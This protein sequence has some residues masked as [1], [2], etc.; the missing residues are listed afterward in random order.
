MQLRIVVRTVSGQRAAISVD[1]DDT[2]EKFQAALERIHG[3]PVPLQVLLLTKSRDGQMVPGRRLYEY[4]LTQDDEILL[5]RELPQRPK[6]KPPIISLDHS[7]S[8]RKLR[9]SFHSNRPIGR[10]SQGGR[11]SLGSRKS[12]PEKIGKAKARLQTALPLPPRPTCPPPVVNISDVSETLSQETRTASKPALHTA[13]TREPMSEAAP[14]INSQ[15][16]GCDIPKVIQDNGG[17]KTALH[18]QE[19]CQQDDPMVLIKGDDQGTA[20]VPSLQVKPP[21]SDSL[22]SAMTSGS[23]TIAPGP[24]PPCKESMSG[25]HMQQKNPGSSSGSRVPS[26]SSGQ[27]DAT[28]AATCPSSVPRKVNSVSG[29]TAAV[30]PMAHASLSWSP[31]TTLSGRGEASPPT[32]ARLVGPH[33]SGFPMS[34]G[35]S[36]GSRER[37]LAAAAGMACPPQPTARVRRSDL[38]QI[39]RLGVGAFGVVT[40]E[41]DRR[42]G[43]T[44]ALKA[45]S[46][47]YLAQLRMEY[48][49]LNEKRILKMVESP[50]VVRLIATYN[51][52]EHV[53][54][55]LEAAL[56]GE[57]FTTYERLRLYGSERHARFYVAC[58]TEALTHLHERHVI[59]RDLKPENLLLD[60]RGYCKLTD[61]G[62][63]KVTHGQTYT[64]VG[65][66]DYMA[67]E[68]ILCTGHTKAVDWWMLGV[69]LFELLAG[70]APF[71]ADTTQ[72]VYELVK[73]GID[74][75][76][77]PHEC[78]RLATDLVRALCNH[79]PE[80]R[81]RT[82]PLREHPFFRGFEWPALRALRLTPPHIPHVRGPRDLAN[83]R[84]CD[85]EDPPVTPYQDTGSGWDAGFEDDSLGSSA[86]RAGD[87]ADAAQH[88]RQQQHRQVAT[89]GGG[90][91]HSS[92]GSSHCQSTRWQSVTQC[93]KASVMA[94]RMQV[95]PPASP[96][97]GGG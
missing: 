36:P 87:A 20:P 78:R 41:A 82:P 14:G 9:K 61:M 5:V 2:V 63:A 42:T 43:R 75:V 8:G 88:Y 59:Y 50:F 86:P 95:S 69:L 23:G 46:K 11:K 91:H 71:E 33:N 44:Y 53:Y 48:S 89:S 30:M 74:A 4:D 7:C 73:R 58:V 67:P 72:Q 76:R 17:T 68:V 52:R 1:A 79:T 54:F 39:G 62:L 70:R 90:S 60:S 24:P 80:A 57:L 15:A 27:K 18:V 94:Q 51:G 81:L 37:V 85:G 97:L 35:S 47:G 84:A 45:V 12:D 64:L 56:G 21:R 28:A 96:V 93:S 40:L 83:F 19:L 66:P 65:T 22:H 49:V 6:C 38:Q 34:A 10:K 13:I 16:I 77:F 92:G 25:M 29:T 26:T 3:T 55:L 31:P 32:S